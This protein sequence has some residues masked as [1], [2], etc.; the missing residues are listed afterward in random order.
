MIG[1]FVYRPAPV[2][3]DRGAELLITAKLL[4]HPL[5]FWPI[6]TGIW[7]PTTTVAVMSVVAALPAAGPAFLFIDRNGGHVD[8][9]ASAILYSTALS[10]LKI[11]A[12]VGWLR[13]GSG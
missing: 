4:L 8:Q 9:V 12:Q 3:I 13:T 6:A 1:V 10:F 2:R 5:L 7:L 11:A